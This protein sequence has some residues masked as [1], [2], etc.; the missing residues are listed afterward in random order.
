MRLR[1]R[2][3]DPAA[4]SSQW[5]LQS[6]D[7][8]KSCR[9]PENVVAANSGLQLQT[10]NATNCR[11]QWST[12]SM[13]SQV[14]QKFGFFEATIKTADIDGLNNAFWLVTKDHFEIDSAKIHFPN[15]V[16]LTLHD[17]N[18]IDGQ[19]PPAVG[20]NSTFTDN[21]SK[22]FHD[23]GVLWTPADIIF[24]VDGEPVAAISTRDSIKDAADI[25]FRRR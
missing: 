21:F 17:N 15:I 9:R 18:K 4:L 7:Y 3:Q 12:G 6:D 2:F 22:A 20:F 5:L 13:I 24:E 25:R 23:Y 16:R 1:D 11:A 10:R 8:L 19:F 14:Q